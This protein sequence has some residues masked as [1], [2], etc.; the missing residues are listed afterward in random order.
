MWKSTLFILLGGATIVA[1]SI[2]SDAMQT[3]WTG[4]QV[5]TL[6]ARRWMPSMQDIQ[7]LEDQ[8]ELQG[9]QGEQLPEGHG[10]PPDQGE[11]LQKGQKHQHALE[12]D[13]VRGILLLG[14][15]NLFCDQLL[16]TLLIQRK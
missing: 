6:S 13:K 4:A 8:E 1:S 9:D 14:A 5:L 7:Q 12:K 15:S 16:T 11:Q 3:Y 10:E 2:L